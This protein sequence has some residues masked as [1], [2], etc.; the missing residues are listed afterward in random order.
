MENRLKYIDIAKGIAIIL[1]VLGHIDFGDNF[2]CNWIY[3]FHMPI[4]FIIS[5]FF[6]TS[7]TINIKDNIIVESKKLLYPYFSFSILALLYLIIKFI[8]G[9]ID[10]SVLSVAIIDTI[11]LNGY[12]A[13]WF[14]PTLFFSKILVNIIENS[15][16]SKKIYIFLILFICLQNY[17]GILDL[18]SFSILKSIYIF[19]NRIIISMIFLKIGSILRKHLITKN[20]NFY[21]CILL[22]IVSLFV[23]QINGFVDL[24]YLVLNNSLLYFLLAF[25]NS[26]IILSV[27][28]N[29]ENIKILDYFGKNSL[30]I[31]GTHLTTP[32]IMI[33]KKIVEF[34]GISEIIVF[35]FL[36]LI[37]MLAI[38]IIIIFLI[39]KYFIWLIKFP[40]KLKFIKT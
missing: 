5:G 10:F 29:L 6:I 19:V 20:M 36:V 7:K 30:I 34:I 31:Y 4:F 32:L 14:L 21:F 16:I 23:S 22:I 28:K 26:Y 40:K 1:V 3:S 8:L 38:E 2:V 33:C 18:L 25:V 11:T 27:S 39:N 12:S 13:L 9:S 35:D 15:N 24:H 17:L 37:M